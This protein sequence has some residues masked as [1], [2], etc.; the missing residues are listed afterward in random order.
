MKIRIAFVTNSS[1]VSYI[2]S[3]NPEMSEFIRLKT[4][5]YGGDVKKN[6]IYD[7]LTQDLETQ[8]ERLELSGNTVFCKK[9]G[10]EK[11]TECLYDATLEHPVEEVDFGTME[12]H[13]LWAYIWGEYLVNARLAT[14]FKGFGAVQVPRDMD[15]FRK[16]YCGKI[17]CED[18]SRRESDQC[19]KRLTA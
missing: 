10:F 15:L 14:E 19:F 1:S 3:W 12:E 13:L 11:K 2:V 17:A 8:G 9:Y 4:K 16:K 5:R 7:L 6:R 18:C